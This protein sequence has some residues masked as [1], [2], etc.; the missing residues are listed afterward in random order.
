MQATA[1][2]IGVRCAAVPA[3]VDAGDPVV[4][5]EILVVAAADDAI[6]QQEAPAAVDLFK[7]LP[8]GLVP[9]NV[10]APWRFPAELE[11]LQ[12]RDEVVLAARRARGHREM[13]VLP[14]A[15]AGLDLI[16]SREPEPRSRCRLRGSSR[17]RR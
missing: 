17:P 3:E 7:R 1:A 4:F 10:A 8:E 5:V 11:V 12:V 16:L 15:S 13:G 2:G 6:D 14:I 9:G